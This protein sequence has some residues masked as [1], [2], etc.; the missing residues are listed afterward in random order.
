MDQHITHTLK[1]DVSPDQMG[2]LSL[3]I[4]GLAVTLGAWGLLLADRWPDAA[5][6]TVVNET[7]T[8]VNETPTTTPPTEPNNADRLETWLPEASSK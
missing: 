3:W 5:P 4:V 8:V 7:T 6:T 2:P 1:V